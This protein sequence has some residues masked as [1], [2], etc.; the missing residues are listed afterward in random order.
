MVVGRLAFPSCRTV[1]NP[2]AR[3]L[4]QPATY[5][6]AAMLVC[7][8]A[9]LCHLLKEDKASAELAAKRNNENLITL[10]AHAV[11][12]SF[13]EADER[14]QLIRSAYKRDPDRLALS[15]WTND[16]AQGNHF[17]FQLAVAGP[18]G[19]LRVHSDGEQRDALYIGDRESFGVHVSAA[20]DRLFISDPILLRTSHRRGLLLTRRIAGDDGAFLG[21]VGAI[22]D[23]Q[24]LERFYQDVK[25]SAGD[26][27]SLWKLDGTVIAAGANGR[28]RSDI[29]GKRFPDAGMFEQL[30]LAPNGTYWNK[31]APIGKT[32]TLNRPNDLKRLV[33]YRAVAG[34]PLVVS[35][36]ASEAAIFQ[37]TTRNARI[38]WGAAIVLTLA[39]FVAVGLGAR[40]EWHL[41]ATARSLAK[42]KERFEA[43]ITNMPHGLSMID[44]DLRIIVSNERYATMYGL[45]AEDVRAGTPLSAIL[46]KRLIATDPAV[47]EQYVRRQL[48]LAASREPSMTVSE[49]PDGRVFSVSHQPMADGGALAVHQDITLQKRAEAHIWQ[50]AHHDGLTGLANRLAFQQ[51]LEFACTRQREGGDRFAVHMLDLDHFKEINDT[52]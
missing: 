1:S 50:L 40:R 6:G 35:T 14:L 5:F 13:Q 46:A 38:Y 18:D 23:L 32:S 41:N 48:A 29:I 20:E 25:L 3:A 17:T 49:L 4:L 21:V 19:F 45:T 34:F 30:K 43:A 12:R 39:I 7:I 33:S 8:C 24:Q 51:A 15:N 16:A 9:T 26:F 11:A 42:T 36:G 22:I 44:S 31:P 37:E 2:Y 47:V 52:L 27:A 10:F 28:L